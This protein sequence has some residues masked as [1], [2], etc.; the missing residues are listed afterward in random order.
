[1]EEGEGAGAGLKIPTD[2]KQ[3]RPSRSARLDFESS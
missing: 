2:R 3:A 1:M